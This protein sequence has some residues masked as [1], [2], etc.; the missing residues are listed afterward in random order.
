MAFNK[1]GLNLSA[2]NNLTPPSF[3]D[4][5]ISSNPTEIAN[6]I[7]QK[8]NQVTSFGGISYLG[9]GIM[10]TLFFYLV[11]KLGDF[12]ELKGQP[13]STVRATGIAGGITAIIGIQMLSIGYFTEYYHAVIFIGILLVSTLW[14]W[15]EDKR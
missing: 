8:A 14:V 1:V 7:P 6:Q 2:F 9:L 5:N 4:F 11:F 10:V 15:Y 13:F 3:S 12:L